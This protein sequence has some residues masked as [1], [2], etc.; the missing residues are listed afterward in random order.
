MKKHLLDSGFDQLDITILDEL[1]NNGRVSVAD[2]ARKI[3]LS[4][5]AVHN[6][7]KRLE[8]EG[9]I[10]GYVAVIDREAAGY[11]L[12]CFVRL[13][14]Q[15]HSRLCEVQNAVCQLDAVLECFRTTGNYDLLL[16]II[17]HDHKELDRLIQEHLMTLPGIDRIESNVVLAEV[18]STTNLSLKS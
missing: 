2:L 1:Q 12:L 3:H 16:K 8:R 15:P 18:K 6:R 9:V 4:Q 13:S 11:D 7:I 10:R 5:P 14:V 17:V